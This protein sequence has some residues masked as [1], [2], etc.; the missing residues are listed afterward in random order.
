[1]LTL[2][3]VVIVLGVLELFETVLLVLLLR[4]LGELRQR[5]G[6]STS[7]M[8]G[9]A[10]GQPAPSL[11]V[12]DQQG[13]SIRIEDIK[14]KSVLLFILFDC[15]ACELAIQ[16]LIKLYRQDQHL[17]PLII[18]RAEAEA[19]QEYAQKHKLSLPIYRPD[20]DQPENIYGFGLFPSAFILDENGIIRAKGVVTQREPLSA[21][22]AEAFP[23]PTADS[24]KLVS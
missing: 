21:L 22:L 13:Q 16:D 18:G 4:G 14:E 24:E 11:T 17:R 8:W 20:K 19:N 5:E 1:M 2:W 23:L 12:Y 15:P 9:V 6:R 7:G 10:V 3:I